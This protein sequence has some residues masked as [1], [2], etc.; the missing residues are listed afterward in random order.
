MQVDGDIEMALPQAVGERQIRAQT[1]QAAQLRRNDDLIEVG[2]AANDRG[3]RGFDQ[4]GNFSG[5]I[6]PPYGANQRRGE[7]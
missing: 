7:Y 5:R 6:V 1:G 4:V 3:G 2:I